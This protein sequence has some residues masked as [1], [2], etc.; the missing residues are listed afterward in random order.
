MDSGRGTGSTSRRTCHATSQAR[1]PTYTLAFWL[2]LPRGP[3][4]P[5]KATLL[6]APRCWLPPP[7]PIPPPPAKKRMKRKT[8][9]LALRD[10]AFRRSSHLQAAYAQPQLIQQYF[11]PACDTAIHLFLMVLKIKKETSAVRSRISSKIHVNTHTS[12][13]RMIL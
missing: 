3:V 10:R 7:P 4:P 6:G 5:L 11:Q 8:H 2:P 1:F 12:K 9:I 13:V